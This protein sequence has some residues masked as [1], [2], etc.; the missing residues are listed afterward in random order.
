MRCRQTGID[1]RKPENIERIKKSPESTRLQ[2][3]GILAEGE[4][5]KS[6]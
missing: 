2:G 4:T 1:S 5:A 6:A 3:F